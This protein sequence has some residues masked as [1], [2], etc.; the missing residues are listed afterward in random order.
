MPIPEV[1]RRKEVLALGLKPWELVKLEDAGV[2]R[3]RALYP[4]H[5]GV[6]LRAEVEAA[7]KGVVE[8][9]KGT[10]GTKG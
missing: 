2:I 4:G 8:G 6:Y 1:L 9:T 5:H 7:L 3:R 10:G